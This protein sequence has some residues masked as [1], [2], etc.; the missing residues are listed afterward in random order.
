MLNWYHKIIAFFSK[1]DED[2]FHTTIYQI[3]GIQAKN[4]DLYRQAF[5]HKSK[6]KENN[7][8]L[9]FLGDSVLDAA[10][11]E[12]IYK[13]FPQMSEGELSKLRA[14]LVSRAMLN[15]L[16]NK[17]QLL[18]HLSFRDTR[19]VEGLRNTEGNTLEALVGAI[20]LDQSYEACRI[21]I[22]NKLLSPF[23]HWDELQK[24]VVDHKSSVFQY[25]QKNKLELRFELIK[26]D[27]LHDENR[28]HIALLIDGEKRTEAYGKS[29]KTAEQL[30]SKKYLAMMCS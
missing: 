23:I 25:C 4:I 12:I 7:E 9:E 28:F 16:G 17:L 20:Y 2:P 21:F 26:E 8:R 29:K 13:E 5:R 30:A 27:L 14:K 10:I 15:R 11:S 6:H 24:K 1:R 22:Q 19:K 18:D 3:T